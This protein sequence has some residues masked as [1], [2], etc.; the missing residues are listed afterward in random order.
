[1]K[2]PVEIELRFK[3]YRAAE[4]LA[5]LPIFERIDA[6]A[7]RFRAKDMLEATRY[8]EFILNYEPGLAP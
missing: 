3:N 5:Y 6:H 1:V 4:L 8:I 2:L 7:I